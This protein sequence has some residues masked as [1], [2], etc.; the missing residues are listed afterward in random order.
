MSALSFKHS[1]SIVISILLIFLLFL[2]AWRIPSA[3]LSLGLIFL[4]FGLTATSYTIINR[5]RKAYRQGKIP[6]SSSIRNTLLEIAAIL[7]AMFLA[8]LAGRSLSEIA[9]GYISSHPARLI[10]GIGIGI[11]VGWGIGLFMKFAASR[12]IKDSSGR[13]MPVV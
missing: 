13:E 1:L 3:G 9:A 8:G 4:L 5:N 7:L 6:L 12:L 10:A 11:L 2:T